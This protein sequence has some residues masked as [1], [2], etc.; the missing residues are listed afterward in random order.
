V[1]NVQKKATP[2]HMVP[3]CGF[4]GRVLAREAAQNAQTR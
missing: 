1:A 2:S 4:L 3:H